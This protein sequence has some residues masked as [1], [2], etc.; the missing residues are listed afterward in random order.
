MDDDDAAELVDAIRS[1][2]E[3]VD[4]V[5]D[6]IAA[7]ARNTLQAA[8]GLLVVLA[9]AVG[10]GWI[11]RGDHRVVVYPVRCEGT[12]KDARC[13]GKLRNAEPQESF[14]GIAERQEV[15]HGNRE[16]GLD[17]MLR[18]CH[19]Q[20]SEN[21]DCFGGDDPARAPIWT[22]REG[23]L[24][25]TGDGMLFGDGHPRVFVEWWQW[26]WRRFART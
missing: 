13:I 23:R 7:L 19:V 26:W 14:R 21:W 1:V 2:Q 15:I 18:D 5:R 16:G 10:V 25:E 9:I 11:S 20:D 8:S 24:I 22:M 3:S 6:E 17:S 4:N 12:V